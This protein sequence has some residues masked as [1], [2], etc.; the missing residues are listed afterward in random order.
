MTEQTVDAIIT[1]KDRE[2]ALRLLEACDRVQDIKLGLDVLS[3]RFCLNPQSI[4]QWYKEIT[5]LSGT[6]AHILKPN[7]KNAGLSLEEDDHTLY[8]KRGNDVLVRWNATKVVIAE[9]WREA[10]KWTKPVLEANG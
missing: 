10:D 3:R 7:H 9:I 2:T 6:L 5:A 8:L 4:Y 1:G